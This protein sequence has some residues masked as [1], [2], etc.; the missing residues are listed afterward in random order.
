MNHVPGAARDCCSGV[1]KLYKRA[2]PSRGNRE[3]QF[4]YVKAAGVGRSRRA[5]N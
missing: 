4:H 2:R 3:P 1:G 5:V